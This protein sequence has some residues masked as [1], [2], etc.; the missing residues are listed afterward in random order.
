MEDHQFKVEDPSKRK[1]EF[2]TACDFLERVANYGSVRIINIK[3]VC[4]FNVSADVLIVRCQ[5]KPLEVLMVKEYP[6]KMR[7]K[8]AEDS[9]TGAELEELRAKQEIVLE[10][11]RAEREAYSANL[12]KILLQAREKLSPEVFERYKDQFRKT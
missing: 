2:H 11:V 12:K 8:R 4:R 9:S 6:R 1:N 7:Q 10:E 3:S 5:R